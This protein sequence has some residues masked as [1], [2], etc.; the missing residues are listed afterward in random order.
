MEVLFSDGL[1]QRIITI[2][3]VGPDDS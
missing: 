2:V 3:K 1:Q